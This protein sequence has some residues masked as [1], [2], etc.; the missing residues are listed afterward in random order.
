[1]RVA[2]VDCLGAGR[3]G[4]RLSTVDVIGVGPRLIAGILESLGVNY[5]FALCGEVLRDPSTLDGIDLMLVSGM[6]TDIPSMLKLAKLINRRVI[7]VAGGPSCVGYEI[8]LRNGY[9]FVVWGESEDKLPALIKHIDSDAKGIIKIPGVLSYVNGRLQ[10]EIP[11]G[12][13]LKSEEIWKYKPSIK[14]IKEYPAWW[15]ARVYVEVV[16]GCSNFYRTTLSL[17]NGRVCSNCGLCRSG[18]LNDRLNCPVGIPPGCAYCSV[19]VLYGPARSRPIEAI[20]NEV[21][22]LIELGVRRIVLSAPDFLDFGRDWLVHPKPLTDPRCPKPNLEAINTL[23]AKLHE[24][25]EVL[26]GE[27]FIMM[28]NLKPNLVDEAVAKLLGKYFKGSPVGIGLESGDNKLHRALGRPSSVGEVI[29][30]VKLLSKYGIKAH[31]YLIHGLPS[32]SEETVYNTINALRRLIKYN[33]EKITLYRF[34]PLKYTAFEG[35]SKPGPAIK[36]RAVRELYEFVRRLNA[37]L[38]RRELGKEVKAA[39]VG[40]KAPYLITYPLPHG[41]VTLVRGPRELLGKVVRIKYVKVISDREVLGEL[42]EP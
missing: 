22:D 9:N 38:K 12:R 36:N 2:V 18:D 30:A 21:R 24:I 31:I 8:L 1:M 17:P 7:K 40:F 29:K 19:P 14:V 26:E 34:T 3:K 4:K 25:P 37:E 16:R 42:V 15:G 13:Y 5:E 11:L 32:E 27:V 35:Y 23:L 39:V 28:E 33:L 6:S 20:V 41:P 10:G